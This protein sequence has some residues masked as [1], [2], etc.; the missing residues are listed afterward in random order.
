VQQRE[1][2]VDRTELVGDVARFEHDESLGG[3]VAGQGERG[4]G[5]VHRR[6]LPAADLQR[7]RVVGREHPA[8]FGRDADGQHVEPLA[9]YRLED[10]SGGHAGDRVLRAASAEDDGHA[11][12]LRCTHRGDGT[13][14]RSGAGV[15]V[16]AGKGGRR[17]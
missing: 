12:P 3:R 16:I 8:T 4:A 2:D 1:D 15:D 7:R 10:A 13:A 6:Q 9:V 14:R 5:G 11:L 17:R